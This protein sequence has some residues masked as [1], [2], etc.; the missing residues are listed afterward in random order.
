MK[1]TIT[2]RN[3]ESV[4]YIFTGEDIRKALMKMYA[5]EDSH[6]YEFS[7]YGPYGD[8]HAQAGLVIRYATPAEET[9]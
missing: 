6:D 7:V 3:V 1:K 5:I 2:Y 9:A 8:N 4:L